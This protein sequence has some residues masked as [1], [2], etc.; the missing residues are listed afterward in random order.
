MI[1]DTLINRFPAD[2]QI[3]IRAAFAMLGR[4]NV[5]GVAYEDAVASFVTRIDPESDSFAEEVQE[6]GRKV[7]VFRQLKDM[8]H[9]FLEQ[10]QR[11]A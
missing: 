4:F 9:Q 10:E 6:V 1:N 3:L 2:E 7:R 5:F 8:C 11:H